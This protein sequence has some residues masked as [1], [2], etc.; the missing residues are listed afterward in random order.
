MK[1]LFKPV[2]K[3]S[4]LTG[5]DESSNVSGDIIEG[6]VLTRAIPEI[7]SENT[8]KKEIPIVEILDYLNHKTNSALQTNHRENEKSDSGQDKRR[9][10]HS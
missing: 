6:T 5:P 10:Y 3:R 7:T 1:N 8:S 2:Q 4:P 9:L